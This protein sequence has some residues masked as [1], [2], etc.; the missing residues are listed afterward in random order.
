VKA[1]GRDRVRDA[2][3]AFAATARHADLRRAQVA[4]GLLWAS[5]WA[6]QVALAVVAFAAGGATE[7]GVVAAVRVLPGAVLTPV[8]SALADRLPRDRVLIAAGLLRGLATGLATATL[9]AGAPVWTTYALAVL[10]TAAFTVVRPAHSALLP[11]LCNSPRD[12]TSATVVRGL[13]DAAGTLLGP[14]L[15]A[16]GLALGSPALVVGGVAVAS[17]LAAGMIARVCYEPPPRAAV[18]RRRLTA[19]AADGFRAM[20]QHPDAGLVAGIAVAQTFTR[21]ALGVLIVTFT[22]DE[23]GRGNAD[24]GVLTAAIG[25]GA[26]VGAVVAGLLAG[27]RDLARFE[28]LGVALWGLPLIGCAAV[29][30]L[31]P[32]LVLLAVIGVGNALVDV[33]LFTLPV[34]LVPDELLGRFFG[35]FESVAC[36]SVAAGSLV[37]PVLVDAFGVRGALLATGLVCPL[38]V[39]LAW[40]RL[41]RL[42]RS[43]VDRDAVVA[44]LR[45]V[46]FLRPLPVAAIERLAVG[47]EARDVPAGVTVVTQGDVGD[48]YH[49]LTAGAVAVTQGGRHIAD[50]RAGQGFGE[51]ALL[52]AT[53]RT[54]TVRTTEP[55]A[56]L[57]IQRD[58]FLAAVTG[59]RPAVAE[60][61]ATVERVLEA[62]AL[63]EPA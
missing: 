24:V 2:A 48:R 37:A 46:P 18:V 15:A 23:L 12:L 63:R 4:F 53:R 58:A 9:V 29:P 17:L 59:Y 7:V 8:A 11:A 16:L 27:G 40:P 38:L 57:A 50:M 6:F 32:V 47:A 1:A 51:I 44:A 25:A 13:M 62:D 54:A 34:R 3:A 52:R 28:G 30:H 43:M 20:V 33:G 55:C 22:L 41:H 10:A 5:E 31:A 26:V 42:D 14:A 60:A 61:T 36:V 39:V 45:A 35:V 56:L 49:V 21:G 19:E